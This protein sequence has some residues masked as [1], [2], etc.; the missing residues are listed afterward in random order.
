MAAAVPE[1]EGGVMRRKLSPV[2]ALV[3]AGVVAAAALPSALGSPATPGVTARTV[4]IGGTFPL[5]GPASSYAPIPVGMKAYFS[6]VNATKGRDGKRGVGGRQ[7]V[8]KY[9]DDAYNPAQT[10]QLTQ[11]LVQQ[12]HVFAVVGGLGTPSQEA[13][14]AYL[15]Q[16]KVPQI[17]V[18]TGATEFGAEQSTY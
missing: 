15:N 2:I 11:Q 3:V 12:D 18:S 5:S 14:R 1:P 4:T 17:Y 7:I 16:Q 13:V 6:Y 9:Y 8:W 10:V